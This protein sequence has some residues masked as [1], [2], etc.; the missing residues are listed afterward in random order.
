[1]LIGEFCSL[2]A[3][4]YHVWKLY[5]NQCVGLREVQPGRTSQGLLR[6]RGEDHCSTYLMQLPSLL[7]LP[8]NSGPLRLPKLQLSSTQPGSVPLLALVPSWGHSVSFVLWMIIPGS[9]WSKPLLHI[10]C[11]VSQVLMMGG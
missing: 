3:A 2:V 11:P 4:H 6:V 5:E 9:F 10:S 7:S 8:T 1:M